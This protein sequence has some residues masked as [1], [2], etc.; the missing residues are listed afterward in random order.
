MFDRRDMVQLLISRGANVN[1]AA[2]VTT[3][4]GSG[5]FTPLKV[6][7]DAGHSELVQILI[8]TGAKE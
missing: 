3:K 1:T 8:N 2:H 7:K 6:A 5:T 4:K